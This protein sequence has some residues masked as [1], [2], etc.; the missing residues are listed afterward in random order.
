MS[1]AAT[2]EFASRVMQHAR[3]HVHSPF[4]LFTFFSVIIALVAVVTHVIIYNII[5]KRRESGFLY[6]LPV[7]ATG[8]CDGFYFSPLNISPRTRTWSLRLSFDF[9]TGCC[10]CY[11][12][13]CCNGIYIYMCKRIHILRNQYNIFIFVTLKDGG[14]EKCISGV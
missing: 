13:C 7:C 3:A 10:R 5:Y 8:L 12:C 4:F 11:C 1:H 2:I 9:V 6:S 14:G